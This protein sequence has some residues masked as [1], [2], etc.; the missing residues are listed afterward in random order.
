MGFRRIKR[1]TKQYIIVALICIM[2]IGG[3]ALI[4]IT[5]TM[6]QL[7][8]E[9]QAQ[10]DE[11]YRENT[12]NQRNLYVASTDIR[13][14]DKISEANTTKMTVYSSQPEAAFL[15]EKD[16][17]KTALLDIPSGTHL[18]SS[19]LTEAS[20]TAELREAEYSIILINANILEDDYTDIRIMFPNGEDYIVLSKKRLK[21]YVPDSG[22]CYLWLSEEEILRM[23]SA[24]VDAY[25]YTGTKIYTTKYIEPKLQEESQV[26]Y[27]PGISTLLLI[28][29]NPNIL[30][31]AETHLSQQV[32]KAMENRLAASLSINV[33]EIDWELSPNSSAGTMAGEGLPAILDPDVNATYKDELDDKMAEIDYGP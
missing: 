19:M 17:G 9:Y 24:A 12:E 23:A 29:D 27:K 25:L 8:Q 3:A 32:R 16:M 11:A 2:V 6:K 28:Q 20:V 7:R 5:Q 4:T 10:L 14:G 18:L 15:R 21:D 22:R 13:A 30:E 31:T 26:T 33:G 1:T